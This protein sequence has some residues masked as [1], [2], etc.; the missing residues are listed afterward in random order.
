MD[1]RESLKL[2]ALGALTASTTTF[3]QC[4]TENGERESVL[5]DNSPYAPGRTP[6]EKERTKKLLEEQFFNEKE[7][8]VIAI[9]SDIIIPA[10]DRSGSATDAGVPDFIEFITKDMP[11]NKIPMR[12]GLAWLDRESLNRFSK[13]FESLSSEQ[14]MEIVDDIGNPEKEMDGRFAPGKAFFSKL[15]DLVVTGFYTSEIGVKED[16]GYVG[17]IPNVWDGVPE[18]ILA[19]YGLNYNQPWADQYLNIETR[20]DV[21]QWDENGNLTNN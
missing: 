20:A 3:I 8:A 21:A 9:L 4:K 16:L 19:E 15:R 2:L 7:M 11:D 10:D 6:S 1:R 17:N 13:S 14:Q 12:G 5:T 18:D